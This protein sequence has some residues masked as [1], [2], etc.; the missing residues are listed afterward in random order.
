MTPDLDTQLTA[1]EEG[2]RGVAELA[3]GNLERPVPCCPEWDL[4]ALVRHLGGV[5]AFVGSQVRARSESR[6]PNDTPEAPEGPA[7]LDWY[8]E[9]HASLTETLRAAAPDEAVWTFAGEPTAAFYH[10][11]MMHETTIHHHDARAAVGEIRPI[12]PTIAHDG[13][14]ELFEVLYGRGGDLPSGSL[15]LHRTD[16]EGEWMLNVVD[17]ELVVTH[18][19]GKADAAVRGPAAELLLL[20]WE[21]VPLDHDRLEVFGDRDVVAGWTALSA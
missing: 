15:H 20:Q 9:V 3:A 1:I 21:R 10:R 12:D 11:R 19:H 8:A 13:L 17:G 5:Y 14:D 16:G 4:Q 18:E 6:V 7:V 2:G